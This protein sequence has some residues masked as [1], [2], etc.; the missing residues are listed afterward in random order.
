MTHQA[1][2]LS[3][4]PIAYILGSI[5]FGLLVGKAKGIDPRTSGSK[6]IG[7][8]NV[9]R[10]LGARYFAIVFLLDMLKGLLPMLAA[11]WVLR[12]RATLTRL[13]FL[14]WIS[15]GLA[16]MV[17]HMFSLF[18]KFT[19]GK[20]VATAAGIVLGLW[21]FFT[22][23]GLIALAVFVIVFLIWRYVSLGSMVA[24][25]SFSIAYISIGLARDWPIA[26]EQLPLTIS[27]ILVALLI[28]YR[29]RANITRLRAGT[30][31]KIMRK[32]ANPDTPT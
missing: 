15:V 10:L 20:G 14:L 6:N 27:A 29:H 17:G 32:P 5:P 18:L 26:R 3:L 30:E 22:L 1:Q 16:A 19:G 9:G 7:A 21:P 8:T 28:V 12:S 13:D 11:F 24:A 2:L 25:I 31:N 4:L 23:P